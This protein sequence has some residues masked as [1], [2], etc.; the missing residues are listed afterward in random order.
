[1]AAVQVQQ[2]QYI[3][4]NGKVSRPENSSDT[5]VAHIDD[6]SF[7]DPNNTA[8]DIVFSLAKEILQAGEGIVIDYPNTTIQIKTL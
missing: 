1:M 7:D 4:I 6:I 2:A 3:N 8:N 5:F